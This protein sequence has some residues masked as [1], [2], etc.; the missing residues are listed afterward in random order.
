MHYK[1]CNINSGIKLVK[2]GHI[3]KYIAI[4]T[5]SFSSHFSYLKSYCIR[6]QTRLRVVTLTKH[7]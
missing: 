2:S 5:I 6:Q 1:Q 3:A 7:P 4:L